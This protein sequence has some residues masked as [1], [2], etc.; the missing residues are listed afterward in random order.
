VQHSDHARWAHRAEERDGEWLTYAGAAMGK[1]RR[2]EDQRRQSCFA[3]QRVPVPS[4]GA[5]NGVEQHLMLAAAPSGT[6]RRRH[7]GSTGQVLACWDRGFGG[8][9]SGS[10]TPPASRG[11]FSSVLLQQRRGSSAK[12][13]KRATTS[14][15]HT[16]QIESREGEGTLLTSTMA[17]WA[18]GSSTP[19]TCERKGAVAATSSSPGTC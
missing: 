12:L 14:R 17:A 19:L 11:M 3:G 6:G 5:L 16:Y 4:Q 2:S 13:R 10:Q 1:P 8:C 9:I 7:G 15:K 18:P